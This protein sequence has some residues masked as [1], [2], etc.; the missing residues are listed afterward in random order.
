MDLSLSPEQQLLRDTADR[1]IADTYRFEQRRAYMQSPAGFSRENWRRFAELGLLGLPFAESLGGIGGGGVEVMVL[2]NAFGRGLVVEPYLACV[3]LSGGLLRECAAMPPIAELIE[4]KA[5]FAF[6]HGE[7]QARY[8]L[9]DVATTARRA[10]GGYVLDGRKTL[11]L[12]GDA[13]DRLLVSARTAGSSRDRRGITLFLVD[14]DARGVSVRGYSTNDGMRAAEIAFDGVRVGAD[15]VIGEVDGALPVIEKVVDQTIAALI[16]EAAGIMT[17]L[18]DLTADYLK[19]RQQFGRPIGSF[20]ALQHRFVDML[21]ASEQAKSM[22]Y[23]AATAWDSN[24]AASRART[25]SAA[26]AEIGRGGRFV[27]Q[28]AVQLHGGIGMTDEYS[29]GHYFKRLTMI[30]ALFGNAD[31]HLAR[32][33]DTIAAET[34]AAQ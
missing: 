11:V 34:A 20:Q 6:A 15:V 1:L 17:R 23:L 8:A 25:V 4:G 22:A 2:M 28:Q 14:R 27:G 31:H 13:A 21:L 19:T 32:F 5:I 33:A 12:N 7:R 3:V 30:D 9:A 10:A 26:K 16:A 18:C 29:V 24:D